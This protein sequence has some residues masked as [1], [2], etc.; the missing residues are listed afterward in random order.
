MISQ[1]LPLGIL[2]EMLYSVHVCYISLLCD[3]SKDGITSRLCLVGPQI[4]LYA[5]VTTND[6]QDVTT[7]RLELKSWSISL[8]T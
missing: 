4:D 7:V 6:F 1:L 8:M 3:F 5:C 2:A